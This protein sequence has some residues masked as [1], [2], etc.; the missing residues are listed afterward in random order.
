MNLL[1]NALLLGLI[2]SLSACAGSPPEAEKTVDEILA[3]KGLRIVE[4]VDKL[5]GF[6]IHGWQSVNNQNVV[7][8]DGPSKNYLVELNMPCRN[9]DYAQ[10]IAFTSF[11]RTVS[12]ND[13]LIVTDGPG[14]AEHCFMKAFYRLEKIKK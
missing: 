10:T 5:V 4:P 6:N 7:L 11:G 2:L 9:L 8:V 3:D 13:K 14:H 1:K 12:R